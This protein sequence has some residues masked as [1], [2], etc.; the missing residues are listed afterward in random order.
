MITLIHIIIAVL[1]IG[2]AALLMVRPTMTFKPAY[3]LTGATLASGAAIMIEH[4]STAAHV[5]VSGIVFLSVVVC[6]L[7]AARYRKARLFTA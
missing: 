4:P 1:G 6:M 5:C 7:A 2:Y 3:V